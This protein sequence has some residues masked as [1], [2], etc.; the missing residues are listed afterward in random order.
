[1]TSAEREIL[2]VPDRFEAL[3]TEDAATLRG[4][5]T[6]VEASLSA[7]DERFL[8]I[9]SAERGGLMILKGVSGAGKSTFAKTANLF[10]EIDIVPVDSQQE[11]TVALR[12]LPATNNP[13]LVIVEGREALGE[14]ARESIESYLHAANNFVR[15]EAGRTSLLVWPVNTDNMVELLTDIA[16]SIGAKALLGFEDEFHLF[17]GPPKSDFIKIADQTIGAL[18]QGASIY[19]LGLSVER[20]DELAVRSDTIGEFL[21]RVRIELQ[22]NVE[23]IQGLMPQESLRVWTIVVSDS[24]AESAVN[25]VTR[26]RDAYADIDRMMTSTNANIVADLQKFPD[27]LGI[28]GTVLDA[29]VVYLDVFSALAVARTFADDSLRQL[30]TE[31]GMSTSKD[32]KAIDRI[33]DS[34]LGI[35]LQGSTLG[36]GR[37]GAKAK[38]NTLSAFSNLTAIA[39]DNDTLINIAIA[40]AL[41]QTGIITDFEPEKLFGKDRK[42]YSDLIVTLPTGESIR[43]EFM[44]RNSTGSADIS[45]YVLKKLEIYGKSIGLFD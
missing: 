5:V 2:R 15:S 36:T 16:R 32:S 45:N 17:T 19:N 9:R 37:R 42:Y 44:W 25:A 21:G 3:A 1:M 34:T 18:N 23:R 8:E 41:K 10:R 39:S 24:N 7:I 28:L 4:V 26:G 40:T 12:E 14:V 20:A 29:R 30:M 33:G 6:P 22:K 43:L 38:G 35:L 11:L 13:R 27:R 31:K